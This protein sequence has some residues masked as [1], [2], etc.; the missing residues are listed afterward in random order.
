MQA[1]S[2]R[3]CNNQVMTE[4]ANSVHFGEDQ[5]E[6]KKTTESTARQRKLMIAEKEA[7]AGSTWSDEPYGVEERDFKKIQVREIQNALYVQV[8]SDTAQVFKGW[9]L[10]LYARSCHTVTE[11]YC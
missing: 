6:R 1:V 9:P 8:L 10:I 4:A 3:L 11:S 7:E 2:A 5:L